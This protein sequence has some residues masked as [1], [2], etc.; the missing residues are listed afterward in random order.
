MSTAVLSAQPI[1]PQTLE[2]LGLKPNELTPEALG[3]V[4]LEKFSAI[5]PAEQSAIALMCD[6]KYP[7]VR[8]IKPGYKA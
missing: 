8:H 7:K 2:Y 4:D 1:N 6:R 3:R 5:D